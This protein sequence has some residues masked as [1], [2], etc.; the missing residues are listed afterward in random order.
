MCLLIFG[1]RPESTKSIVQSF[2]KSMANCTDYYDPFDVRNVDF[3]LAKYGY[4]ANYIWRV[5]KFIVKVNLICIPITFNN[6][7]KACF[8]IRNICTYITIQAHPTQIVKVYF[9]M[10]K[11]LFLANF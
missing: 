9:L 8:R 5:V 1:K 4:L 11:K 2:I 7:L 10:K 3:F 6:P